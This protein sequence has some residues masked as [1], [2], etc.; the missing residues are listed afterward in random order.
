[1]FPTEYKRILKK[2]VEI[3]PV[4]YSKTRNYLNGAVTRLSP[5]ISRGVLS[6]RQVLDHVRSRGYH[7]AQI[8]VF[9]KEL[10]WRDYFQRVAQEKDIDQDIRQPQH[11]VGNYEIPASVLSGS[12]GIA[13]IDQSIHDLYDTGYLHNHCRMYIASIVCNVATSHWRHPA[14]WMYYHLLDGDWAS[15][16]CSWQWVAGA[17]SSK[18]YYAN[19]DN[20]NKHTN[21]QQKGTFLDSSYENLQSSGIPPELKKT[22]PFQPELQLPVS[23]PLNLNP[24]WPTFLYN[25]NNL[26]PLWH[27]ATEG[28]RI[29][30]IEPELF[31]RH[32]VSSKCIDFMLQLSQN[33]PGIQVYVGSFQSLAD[34][35]LQGKIH[36]KEH[37]FCTHYRGIR[38]ERDWIAPE[39]TGYYPSFFSYWKK[40]EKLWSKKSKHDL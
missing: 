31:A 17:N 21:T 2:L 1:M 39:V 27:Q 18:K 4:Q 16:A 15:N 34:Q 20:I 12:T 7:L 33:I 3:D 14:R 6:T 23:A 30:L 8:E 11:P 29:L 19:Q 35:V 37:P 5:Y 13:G 26:D 9:V 25:Y 32:P 22:V 40:I 24:E 38:E 36:Y 10:C 28:N